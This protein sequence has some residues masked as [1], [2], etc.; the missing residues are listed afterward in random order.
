MTRYYSKPILL[1]EFN[2]NKQ[3]H[4]QRNFIMTSDAAASASN[5]EI[6]SKLQLL[7][8]HFPKLKLVWS[9]SPYA[10]AQLFEELKQGKQDPDP[11]VTI[12][13]GTDEASGGI[14]NFVDKINPNIYD[15]LIRL[16][17]IN[18]KNIQRVMT[19]CKNMK[20]LLKK[21]EEELDE[22]LVNKHHAKML[23]EILHVAHKPIQADV[24]DSQFKGLKRGMSKRKF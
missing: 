4:L 8:I 21:S 14:D 2:Q 11:E 3:F 15:F 7:T 18:T 22:I 10:T 20:D 23:W 19:K 6:M 9:P 13:I 12:K 5:H 16:P 1:I 24:K 17:G